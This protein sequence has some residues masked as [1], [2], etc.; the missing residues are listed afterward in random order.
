MSLVPF[1]PLSALS[2]WPDI[3][4]EDDLSLWSGNALNNLDVIETEDEIVIKANVAGVKPNEVDLTFEKGILWIKAQH[5][6]EQPDPKAKHY[7]QASWK[8]SYKVA[9]P[10]TLDLT[11]EPTAKVTD[12]VLTVKFAKAEI[13][14]PKKLKVS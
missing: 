7:S 12:G 14:K 6:D 3:W 2:R 13:T 10:G 1:R 9:V 11:V 5:Q 4:D 8:Y